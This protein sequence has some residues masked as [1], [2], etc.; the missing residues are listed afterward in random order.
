MLI[1]LQIWG[2]VVAG[3]V[4]CEPFLSNYILLDI[5]ISGLAFLDFLIELYLEGVKRKMIGYN[6]LQRYHDEVQA[7][8]QERL[9]PE[10]K[11][12]YGKASNQD[13]PVIDDS[14]SNFK[15]ASR[16]ETAIYDEYSVS[17]LNKIM[18]EK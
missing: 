11:L 13:D 5:I 2:V 14:A 7:C 17:N 15:N 4:K 9:Y 1:G 8:F 10:I 18:T 16:D 6:V 12:K 3:D